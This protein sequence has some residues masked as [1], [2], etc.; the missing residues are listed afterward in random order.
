MGH[1]AR[2]SR[3]AIASMGRGPGI[4]RLA[5]C[6]FI[7][8]GGRHHPFADGMKKADATRASAG[9]HIKPFIWYRQLRGAPA[10]VIHF[11]QIRADF[12]RRSCRPGFLSTHYAITC[13]ATL[14]HKRYS[15]GGPQIATDIYVG[16]SRKLN[17]TTRASVPTTFQGLLGRCGWTDG[18]RN[19]TWMSER[20][21]VYPTGDCFD[22][23]R[24]GW[25]AGRSR[26]RWYEPLHGRIVQVRPSTGEV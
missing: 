6:F 11:G 22:L 19:R 9:S 15:F 10:A 5:P 14:G 7:Y 3:R 18:R 4:S 13:N 16:A 23:A 1:R 12:D 20:I 26:L 21:K 17:S 25:S 24:C 8:A 2:T